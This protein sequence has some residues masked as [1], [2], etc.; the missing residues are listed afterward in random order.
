MALEQGQGQGTILKKCR[1]TDQDRCHHK[2]TVQ[3]W[4]NGRQRE[5]SFAD[6]LDERGRI[7]TGSGR[8]LAEDFQLKV[9]QSNHYRLS[10]GSANVAIHHIS[11]LV[12]LGEGGL[13]VEAAPSVDRSAIGFLRR[14]RRANHLVDVA[15]GY[16]QW[17]MR[18]SA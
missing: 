9:A 17:G 4:A 2:W 3:Y 13:A 14:E 8:K 12:S 11:A 10:F 1:C 6:E 15:R 18:Q 7:M 16:S 5:V